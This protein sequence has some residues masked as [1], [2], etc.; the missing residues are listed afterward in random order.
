M[1]KFLDEAPDVRDLEIQL[2]LNKLCGNDFFNKGDGSNS[3]NFFPPPP[4]P[5]PPPPNFPNPRL[6]PLPSD[7]FNIPNIPRVD[8]FLNNNNFNF[9]FSNS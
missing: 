3:I 6:P 4:P 8:K 7:L 2:R 5:P 1:S 9:D